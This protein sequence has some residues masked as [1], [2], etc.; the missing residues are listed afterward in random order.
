MFTHPTLRRMS[1]AVV[2]LAAAAA[3][4]VATSGTA[5]AAGPTLTSPALSAVV[6]GTSVTA[7]TTVVASSTTTATLAG[8]CARDARGGNYDFPLS[9]SIS[10]TT[11]GT[12]ITATRYL[13]PSTY[14]YW[15]CVKVNG[16]W[17]NVGT[18]K[19]FTVATPAG[20]ATPG[21]SND[22]MPVGDLPGWH[23]V[24]TDN[25]STPLAEGQF[26]GSYASK[27]TSYNGFTDSSG[28]GDFNQK[29]I[30]VHDGSLDLD[31]HSQNGRAQGAAP[32][33]LVNGKWGG[34]VYGRYTVRFKADALAGYGTGWL[35]WSD[36]NN[37]NDGEIDFPESALNSTIKG[38]NHTVGNPAH[39][40]LVFDT[41]VSYL[42]WHTATI[43]W[44]PSA[45]SY[46]LDGKLI[47]STTTSVPTNP[48]HWVLQ[49]ATT[50]QQPAAGTAGHMLIDWVSIYTLA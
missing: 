12:S 2:S 19:S 46:L 8:I 6:T 1:T 47:Q 39:N 21:P 36:A 35:L 22:P 5:A 27:W 17:T 7:T 11:S 15:A 29:I 42:D 14:T 24:F 3:L 45:V 18:V 31:L 34:Q 37:W 32:V 13:S 4:V 49:T 48:L 25:F 28:F 30:S 44:T 40:D 20:P 43:E 23:Q 9:S 10:I 50:G 41:G 38:Y 26:P 33:P 16:Y